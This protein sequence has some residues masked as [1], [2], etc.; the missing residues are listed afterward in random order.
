MRGLVS[1][2]FDDPKAQREAAV[3]L[4]E[5]LTTSGEEAAERAAIVM[6]RGGAGA[7]QL[8]G[9]ISAVGGQRVPGLLT[10]DQ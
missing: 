1:T 2:F 3:I 9:A 4:T 6:A 10:D 5:I 7:R 8:T